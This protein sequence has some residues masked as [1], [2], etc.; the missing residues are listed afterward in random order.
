MAFVADT[1]SNK[2]L[3]APSS[4]LRAADAVEQ[5]LLLASARK[6]F[7]LPEEEN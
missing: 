5:A 3:H 2:L 6:L 7:E 4:A 1:L